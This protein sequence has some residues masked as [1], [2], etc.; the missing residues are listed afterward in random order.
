MHPHTMSTPLTTPLEPG[1]RIQLPS[2]WAEALG[3]HGQVVL[4]RTSDGILVR[5]YPLAT[6]DQLFATPLPIGSNPQENH[7]EDPEV[8]GDD[9]LF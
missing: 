5:R 3:L 6:W 7:E 2:D 9:V 8:T 1:N 4:D